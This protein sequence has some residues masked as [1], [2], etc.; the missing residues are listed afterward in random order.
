VLLLLALS[1]VTGAVIKVSWFFDDRLRS[2][3]E[4]RDIPTQTRATVGAQSPPN[5]LSSS[6]S[7]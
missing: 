3:N 7:T 5:V 2:S 6:V 4:Q 1:F